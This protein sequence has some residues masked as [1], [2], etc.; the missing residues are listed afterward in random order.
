LCPWRGYKRTVIIA[1]H[2]LARILYAMCLPGGYGQGRKREDFD[3][4]R[5][6]VVEEEGIYP[7]KY[8]WRMRMRAEQVVVA[9]RQ[10]GRTFQNSP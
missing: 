6:N 1:A 9:G 4:G 2:R 7:K 3:A 8:Y 5:L 10:Q